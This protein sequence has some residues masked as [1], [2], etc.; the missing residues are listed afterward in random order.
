MKT[1][2]LKCLPAM[3]AVALW[4][5]LAGSLAHGQSTPLAS[6]P[7]PFQGFLVD[8]NGTVLAPT[9]PKNYDVIFRIYDAETAGDVL[10]SE[11]QTV[12]VD[13]GTYSVLLGLGAAVTGEPRPAL[14]SVFITGNPAQRYVEATLKAAGPNGADALIL[15]RSRFLPSPY[16]SLALFASEADSLVNSTNTAVLRAVQGNVGLGKSEPGATLD[17]GGNI[18]FTGLAVQGDVT[19]EGVAT[20]GAWDGGGTIPVGGIIMWSGDTV[21]DGWALCSGATVSGVKTPDLRGRFVLGAGQATGLSPRVIGQT[22]GAEQH[23]LTAVEM[24]THVHRADP[25]AIWTNEAGVHSHSYWSEANVASDLGIANGP[26][27]GSQI[28]R[29]VQTLRTSWDGHHEHAVDPA[30][31]DSSATGGNQPAENMPP[32]YALAYIIRVL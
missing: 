28:G 12:T 24:P 17:V 27:N 6:A 16:A 4:L 14:S 30:P 19:V 5:S 10:W 25:P 31:V 15:P 2:L 1:S 32:F 26:H 7:V 22:G 29:W 8:G 13:K 9:S 11:Q 3:A 21:P 20:A 18:A 23:L